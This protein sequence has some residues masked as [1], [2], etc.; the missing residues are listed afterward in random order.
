MPTGMILFLISEAFLFGALFW[1]YYYLRHYAVMWP[2]PGVELD[3][4]LAIANTVILLSSSVTMWLAGRAIRKD[5][6][7]GLARG[8]AATALLGAAFIG[9]TIRE[10]LHE[11]FQPWSHAYGSI[12]FTLTGFHALH[13]LAGVL[14]LTGLLIRALRGRYAS[15]S[16][17]GIEVG[18]LYWHFVDFI[19]LFVFGTIFIVK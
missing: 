4:T 2:P 3:R 12:F 15:R 17:V 6:R 13:V 11:G 5:S 18:S 7:R 16:F 1:A 9:I 10:W 19:W 14:L 8:I